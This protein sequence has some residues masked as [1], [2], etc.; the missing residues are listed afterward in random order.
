MSTIWQR[1]GEGPNKRYERRQK[2]PEILSELVSK[3]GF[4]MPTINDMLR[5]YVDEGELKLPDLMPESQQGPLNQGQRRESQTN[6]LRKPAYIY[7]EPTQTF[8][9]APAGVDDPVRQIREVGRYAQEAAPRGNWYQEN[10]KWKR[11]T[12]TSGGSKPTR[13]TAA[14]EKERLAIEAVTSALRQK[15]RVNPLTKMTE[16]ILDKNEAFGVAVSAGLDVDRYP[17]IQKLISGYDETPADEPEQPGFW[18][19]VA[20]PMAKQVTD[21]IGNRMTNPG[22]LGSIIEARK[23]MGRHSVNEKQ[24]PTDQSKPEPAPPQRTVE[25]REVRRKTRDGK[26]AIFDANTKQF[27]RYE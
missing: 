24:Q 14:Q 12:D 8:G 10:G 20:R 4:D 3:T 27:L 1:L 26:I 16:P 22:T 18:E 11:W 13:P 2:A 15:I 6:T 23:N 9:P 21:F 5:S 19:N 25:P 7:N 17:E